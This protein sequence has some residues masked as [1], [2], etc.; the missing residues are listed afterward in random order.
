MDDLFVLNGRV[1]LDDK[2]KRLL[3]TGKTLEVR[4]EDGAAA[5]PLAGAPEAARALFQHCG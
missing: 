3:T 5:Y 4:V 2:L 1:R